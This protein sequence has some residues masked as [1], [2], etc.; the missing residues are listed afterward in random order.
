MKYIACL[1]FAISI[2]SCREHPGDEPNG[3]CETETI[4]CC[5]DYGTISCHSDT[6]DLDTGEYLIAASHGA[7][8]GLTELADV[9]DY[10]D[11]QM[12]GY[13]MCH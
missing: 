3:G 12:C 2:T 5:A 8:A 6:Y 11:S 9:I 1:V 4:T 13:H 10:Y 7:P